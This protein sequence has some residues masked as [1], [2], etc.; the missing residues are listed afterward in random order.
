MRIKKLEIMGFKSFADRSRLLFGDGI[1]GVVGPNGCGKSNVV[2]AIRWCMGEMSAKHLRGRA[3]QDIIFSGSDSRPAQGVAEVTLTFHND[4]NVP[5]AYLDYT[6]IAVGR[7]LYRD[8]T[9]EYLINKAQVRLKDIVD[10][11]LGTGVG[12][13]A[14]SI[15]EQGRIGFVVN[16]RPEERRTLIEEVAG[17]TKF[18]AR[19]KAAERRMESTEQN[20]VRVNDIV[21]ELEKQLVALRRQAKKAER[22]RSLRD[23]LR[24]LEV[25]QA[26]LTF[27]RLMGEAGVARRSLAATEQA[28]ADSQRGLAADESSL[29]ADQLRLLEEE[30]ALQQ[31][32]AAS[33]SQDAALA[34]LE[35]DLQHWQQQL[36]AQ[37]S[38][39]QRATY[40]LQESETRLLQATA[41]RGEVEATSAE[42]SVAA[43]G[44]AAGLA[45][46]S[47]EVAGLQA[48]LGA[49]DE[50]LE[51]ARHAALEQVQGATR[52]RS[53]VHEVDRRQEEL[54]ERLQI[55]ADE[56]ASLAP[57]QAQA[58]ARTA[59]LS[60]ERSRLDAGLLD[61]RARR[62]L[63]RASLP[64]R[65]QQV[66]ADAQALRQAQDTLAARH[67][68][69]TS[70]QEVARRLEGCSDG[71][72]TLMGAA[73]ERPVA[74]LRGLVAEGLQV[75][76]E[77][78]AAVEAALGQALQYILVEDAAAAA[79]AIAYLQAQVG[80]RSGFVPPVL[81]PPA[82][83]G[84][85]PIGVG[86]IGPA[87]G[88]VVSQA[89]PLT[90]LLGDVL[91][92]EDLATALALP[93]G[94]WRCVTRAGEVVEANGTVVGG[95][96]DGAG[97]LASRRE[98][99]ELEAVV[100]SCE[101]H[102]AAGREALRAAEEA[103][104]A[105]E[106]ELRAVETDLH[107]SE[108]R[109]LALDKDRD[110]ARRAAQ[111]LAQ[112]LSGLA[113]RLLA[114]HEAA[115]ALAADA[116]LGLQAA[117]AAEAQ[118][119]ASEAEMAE[120][121]ERR[122]LHAGRL[123]QHSEALTAVK[124]Q[125]AQQREQA[126]AA[127]G[128]AEGLRRSIAEL[129][130]RSARSREAIA[131]ADGA[132]A[133]LSAQQLGGQLQQQELAQGA[134]QQRDAL[135]QARAAYEDEVAQ[136]QMQMQALKDLRRGS[137]AL[138]AAR[139]V[140]ALCLQ[141]L[142][143]ERSQL[144]AQVQERHD[145]PMAHA[146]TDYHLL[147]PPGAAA[148]S[149][150]Q[151]LER[152]LKSL[153]A[154]NLTA[155]EECA[156]VEGRYSFLHGQQ[157]DLQAA[158]D[159]L[160]RAIARINKASRERFREAFDAVNEMFQKVYPRL[161]RGGIA[162]LELTSS[163][164]LLEAGVDI[165]AMPPGK[166]L[167]N[168]G[169]LSGGE[170]ALTATALIFSIFLIKPSP[171]CILDEVDAPLDEA[172]VG[173]FNEM[174]R[175]ISQVSQFIVITHNKQTMLQADRLYGITMEEPGMSKVVA[176]DLESSADTGVAA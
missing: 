54:A 137:E 169:L 13:R 20:L 84:V 28:L 107:A 27:L 31:A 46:Q 70:L 41:E 152:G 82:D 76:A 153:G 18:K 98:I 159:V 45:G 160:R 10:L 106:V 119:E 60:D 47:D 141:K 145:L 57:E 104:Q 36:Q 16:S 79:A 161:F 139:S 121:Q 140:S 35:R 147:K 155:I 74:G 11:F 14:Y 167:Q 67:S 56:Q 62:D 95:S 86:I 111:Q 144:E 23:E 146:V 4:G 120:L 58:E 25:H 55:A 132:A 115:V 97:L 38:Q 33:A 77:L 164:D 176:V 19:K 7:R 32:Q 17:I 103:V 80:G 124:V 163:D 88:L 133:E 149:R 44:G 130:A 66:R 175:E 93:R 26:V 24:Q 174:L 128:R 116:A 157:Q 118:Q 108:L 96:A 168:V 136:L 171:F 78:E 71:V 53:R 127:A 113:E 68:R 12:T 100:A 162:R 172:N 85:A 166:K 109:A 63:C 94:G 43:A 170:K 50:A 91:L 151:E 142:A 150:R 72:R 143:L 30:R 101:G 42:L 135:T 21:G 83:P 34:A 148:S 2:D 87:L 105:Q 65:R 64:A 29:E 158:L 73:G 49:L 22:Y 123:R 75:P 131:A 3:M 126:T 134:Q 102:V 110:A 156:E 39:V 112:R 154:I 69:L 90:A 173:R 6:E 117:L 99:R 129:S 5:P 114:G 165:V 40:E 51:S 138:L 9:S 15:I 81:T 125:L 52:L 59:A 89:P 61:C 37:A 1:T 92:V 8:G 48:E 122:S